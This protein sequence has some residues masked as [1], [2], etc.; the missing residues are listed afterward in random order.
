MPIE[1]VRNGEV[2]TA[3]YLNKIGSRVND[4]EKAIAAPRQKNP[5]TSP[6]V[7]NQAA[8]DDTAGEVTPPTTFV[9]TGRTI[10]TVQVFDQDDT[11]YA[12]VQRIETINFVNGNGETLSLQFANTAE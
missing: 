10:S 11:N 4:R 6:E 5:P 7:Q 3:R 8:E 2:I 9:E 12:E 1:K